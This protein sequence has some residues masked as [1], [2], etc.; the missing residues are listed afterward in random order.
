MVTVHS[1]MTP[2]GMSDLAGLAVSSASAVAVIF[3]LFTTVYCSELG[4]KK[5]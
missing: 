1:A 3:S 5:D 2:R 4:A